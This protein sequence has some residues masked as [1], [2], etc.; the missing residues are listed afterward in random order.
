MY[1]DAAKIKKEMSVLGISAADKK[2]KF[3]L[4][5]VLVEKLKVAQPYWEKAEKLNP[6][7]QEVTDVLFSIYQD[8]GNDPG[9]ARLVK[10]NKE[11]GVDD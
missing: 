10:K 9:M 8:L 7:D 2:K 11:Q 4:D 1:A 5:K 6:K 3:D